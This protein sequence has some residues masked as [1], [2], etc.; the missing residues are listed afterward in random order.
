M[1]Q[2]TIY[3]NEETEQQARAAAQAEG[4]SLSRWIAA[5]IE[6]PLRTEWPEAV[7]SLA[8]AWADLPDAETL[9]NHSARDVRRPRL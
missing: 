4:L 8:G 9:R 7:R 6:Q 2:V 3:L 1:G 5:R